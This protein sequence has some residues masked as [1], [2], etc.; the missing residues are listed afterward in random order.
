MKYVSVPDIEE[1]PL[2]IVQFERCEIER[3]G[4]NGLFDR[5]G[6]DAHRILAARFQFGDDGEPVARRSLR[7]NWPVVTL[8]ELKV[9]PFGIAIADG[10][11]QSP[12]SAAMCVLLRKYRSVRVRTGNTRTSGFS[13]IG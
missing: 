12:S 1:H 10:F 6:I 13:L 5:I 9:S 2:E 7:E 8:F 3:V 11:V 4:F